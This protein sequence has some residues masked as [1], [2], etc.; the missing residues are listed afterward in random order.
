MKYLKIKNNRFCKIFIFIFILAFGFSILAFNSKAGVLIEQQ[1][2]KDTTAYE[3]P[4]GAGYYRRVPSPISVGS[5]DSVCNICYGV[6][7]PWTNR[8]G[9]CNIARVN[10]EFSAVTMSFNV[11]NLGNTL[12]LTGGEITVYYIEQENDG[13]D[14]AYISVDAII[15]AIKALGTNETKINNYGNDTIYARSNT[16][17]FYTSQNVITTAENIYSLP[18]NSVCLLYLQ[19]ISGLDTTAYNTE[20]TIYWGY[21]EDQNNSSFASYSPTIDIYY[22]TATNNEINISLP[23][24]ASGSASTFKQIQQ[25]VLFSLGSLYDAETTADIYAIYIYLQEDYISWG[26]VNFECTQNPPTPSAQS[27]QYITGSEQVYSYSNSST[28]QMACRL[29]ISSNLNYI[30]ILNQSTFSIDAINAVLRS[31][32]FFP[33]WSCYNWARGARS[34]YASGFDAGEAPYQTGG[35]GYQAIWQEGYR[36]GQEDSIDTS[37]LVNLFDS[38]DS[39]FS[40]HLFPFLTI[41]EIVGIPFIISVVW[42]IIKQL[43]GGS[44]AD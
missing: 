15:D 22:D 18:Q 19:D 25:N 20:A 13:A 24:N 39:L 17:V 40:I 4:Y 29:S 2:T 16:G 37:F 27:M 21:V 44:G 38:V 31:G 36:Q 8:L 12:G 30:T 33:A 9:Y 6:P 26:Y 34:G 42:F 1:L 11:S 5:A 7:T 28:T 23:Q 43:R 10:F 32:G 3:V 35:L 14:W 41:G